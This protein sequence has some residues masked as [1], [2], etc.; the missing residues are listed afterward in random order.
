MRLSGLTITKF[1]WPDLNYG[2]RTVGKYGYK[3]G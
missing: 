1:E 3:V 2:K